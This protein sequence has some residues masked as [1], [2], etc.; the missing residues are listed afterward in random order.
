MSLLHAILGELAEHDEHGYRLGRTISQRLGDRPV[1]M[2]QIHEAL[3]QLERRGW[4]RGHALE[5]SPRPRRRF[6][7]TESGRAEL[8]A[9]LRRASP[10]PRLPR[11]AMLT[12]LVLF[13]ERD[14][15]RL[16]SEINARRAECEHEL[17]KPLP[18]LPA[19]KRS[20][21]DALRRLALERHRLHLEAERAWMDQCLAV[22]RPAL[23]STPPQADEGGDTLHAVPPPIRAA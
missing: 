13:G 1:N 6:T 20:H 4:A 15:G 23:S 22:L 10:L 14:P 9:W 17:A 18:P 7:I 8:T 3:S 11:D 19:G 12:K 16:V 2:G 5:P 21:G